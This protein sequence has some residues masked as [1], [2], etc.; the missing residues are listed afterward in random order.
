MAFNQQQI[1]A[2][3]KAISQGA[4]KVKYQDREVQYRSL[5]EMMSILNM[6]QKAVG[7]SSGKL[8]VITP[9]FSK[10]VS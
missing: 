10:G 8:R 6:M 2:L 5:D 3:E 1:D 9:E 7:N 4:L